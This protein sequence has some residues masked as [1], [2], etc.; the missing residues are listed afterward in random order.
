[1]PIR[2]LINGADGK[3][4]QETVK[5]IQ[6]DADFVLAGTTNKNSD[7]AKEIA[8]T[9]AQVVIDFT[10]AAVAFQNANII[11]QSGAHPVIGTTGFL[12]EQIEELKKYCAKQKLGGIIAPNFSMGAILMMKFSQQAARYFPNVEII[13]MHHA[14]KK[15]APSGTAKK[16]AE[17]ISHALKTNSE[18]IPIHSVRLPGFVAHQAVIFGGRGET[19]TIRHDSLHRESFMPGVKF[20]CKKVL[21]LKE[22]VYGLENLLG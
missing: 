1:M 22:L 2:I 13:E 6:Q 10:S 16:T 19:L 12:P 7:L 21:E 20:A 4:G 18:N 5:A 15:D 3:M 8:D 11:I 14:T 17:I 9:K